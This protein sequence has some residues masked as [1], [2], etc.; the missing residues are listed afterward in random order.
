VQKVFREDKMKFTMV[1]QKIL[2]HL[3]PPQPIHL[4]HKIKLSGNS[5]A[6]NACYDVLVNVSFLVQKELNASLATTE[7]A[8]D[9]EACDEAI[10]KLAHEIQKGAAFVKGVEAKLWKESIDQ[11]NSLLEIE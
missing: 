3:S 10:W 7:K 6:G 1:S 2:H 5:L 4:E 8:K 11:E 9:I